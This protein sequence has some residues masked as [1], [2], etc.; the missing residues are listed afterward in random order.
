MLI[1]PVAR[2]TP[3]PGF[4]GAHFGLRSKLSRGN[5]AEL[6]KD[7]DTLEDFLQQA[8]TYLGA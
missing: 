4:S 2:L 5:N 1:L 7:T 3:P 6:T 8:H